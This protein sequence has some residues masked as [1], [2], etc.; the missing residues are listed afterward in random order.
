MTSEE[1]TLLA[2]LA[3]SAVLVPIALGAALGWPVWSWLL[4]AALPLGGAGRVAWSIQRRVQRE[5]EREAKAAPPAQDQQPEASHTLVA[6]VAL[7]SAIDGCDFRFSATVYWLP[8]LGATVRHANLGELAVGAI[9]ARAQAITKEEHPSRAEVAQHRLAGELGAV[10]RDASDAVG[11]WAEQVQLMLP[12]ADQARLR[13][14]ADLRK[15]E[16]VW[17][18]ERDHER[19]KRRYLREDVL[20]S[21]ASAVVW[22]LARNDGNVERAPGVIKAL[23]Q[24]SA[25][26]N[27]AE[28]PASDDA[29]PSLNGGSVAGQWGLLMDAL[30][31]GDE[32]PLLSHDFALLLEKCGRPEE[33]EEIRRRYDTSTG[34]ED[35][36]GNRPAPGEEPPLPGEPWWSA[37]TPE[38]PWWHVGRSDQ[39]RPPQA[40]CS[41]NRDFG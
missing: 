20:Q 9:I 28:P 12:E 22:W 18:H 3:I 29:P 17:E 33:A 2:V 24:I 30:G 5:R 31:F 32:V 34:A 1:K 38:E 21:T 4:L 27:N 7:P 36:A 39:D 25:A 13:K 6:D 40:Q 8:A 15:D 23:E 19:S 35:P 26:A 37:R 10:D 16:E 11:A 14:L 41:P